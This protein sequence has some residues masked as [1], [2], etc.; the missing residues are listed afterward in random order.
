MGRFKTKIQLYV[1]FFLIMLLSSFVSNAQKK[2]QELWQADKISSASVITQLN[3]H[4]GEKIDL[5]INNRVKAQD[6]DHL[7]EPFKLQNKKNQFHSEFWGKWITSAI[8]AYSYNKDPELLDI[9]KKTVADLIATQTPEGYIGSFAKEY[10]LQAWDIWGT[11]YVLLGLLDYYDIS[12]DTKALKAATKVAD[13]LLEELESSGKNITEFGSHNGMPSSSILE[14]I[15]KLYKVTG[16]NRYFNFAK[17]IVAQWETP[18][19]P[20]LISKALAGIDVAER[21]ESPDRYWWYREHGSKA[22]EMMTCYEGLLELYRVTGEVLYL[23]AVKKSAQNIIDK[24]INIIGSGATLE[25]WYHGK[26]N[27]IHPAFDVNET[28]VTVYWMKLCYD[29]LQITGDPLYADQIEKS[30]YN[31][32]LGALNPDATSFGYYMPLNG[33]KLPT[34]HQ[35]N[36]NISCCLANGP[37]ALVML[38]EFAVMQGKN[39]IAVNLYCESE[40]QVKLD[41][42]TYVNLKQ[43]TNYPET[44][45][46]SI[47]V[48]PNAVSDFAMLLR[49][50][51]WSNETMIAVNGEY[52]DS[53]ESG[54]YK[55]ISRAWKKG[56][57]ITIKFDF[58]GK[59]SRIGQHMAITRGP[60]VLARDA[61]FEDDAIGENAYI[62]DKPQTI[63]LEKNNSTPENTW[64]SFSTA[65]QFGSFDQHYSDTRVVNF[66]DFAT[67]G[68]NWG[69]QDKYVVWMDETF[70]GR[71]IGERNKKNDPMSRIGLTTVIFRDRFRSETSGNITSELKL[72][73]I[74]E[75]FSKRFRIHNI[76]FWSKHFESTDQAYLQSIARML[77][78]NN[79]KL[80]NIQVDTKYDVSDPDTENREKALSEM[81]IWI[82]VAATLS[83]QMVRV[84]IMNKSLEEAINSVQIL[85]EYASKKG[86]KLLVENHFDLFS[87]PENHVKLY[88]EITNGNFGLLA[89]F[90][91]YGKK[92][93]RYK[94][95]EQI[96]PYTKLVSSKTLMFDK[97]YNHTSFDFARCIRIMEKAGYQGI[98]SLE[99]W[100]NDTD[101]D[102]EKIVDYMIKQVLDN[103]N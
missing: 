59:I 26:E 17:S 15:V 76:E 48:S 69:K 14:P 88:K 53:I 22:Y 102:E 99:Q 95:L 62:K 43:V 79:S 75:Y 85:N 78:R 56:D 49:I 38:P 72:T 25:M 32:L 97:D 55:S 74:P 73:D 77:R 1:S 10:H 6:A 93:D 41:G 101:Y 31:A 64:M 90:G 16:K 42:G 35:C 47:E 84:S 89:D 61:R 57:I 60:I 68:N 103:S 91:N 83:S 5:C 80:I 54:T 100:S 37:R 21:S 81:R 52:Q 39:K 29:L 96:A 23:E 20:K 63:H 70:D 27:Q 87:N 18:E 92:V 8:G 12:K 46:V 13:N 33:Y 98:Y 67:A 58:Q 51:E 82:D 11:K 2:G 34:H 65:L 66:C 45:S 19:G 86:V 4:L 28:C 71:D 94:A 24:E 44:N 9:I 50:P 7:V 40:S 30:T 36:M 3:G